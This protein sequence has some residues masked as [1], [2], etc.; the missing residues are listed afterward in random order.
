VQHTIGTVYG[1]MLNDPASLVRLA[2]QFSKDPYKAAPRAPILYI[3]PA[4]TLAGD[5][6]VV[7]VPAL[8]GR[9]QIGATIGV[10]LGK[11]AA[12]VSKEHALGYVD[13]FRIVA[14]VSL[15]HESFYR[16]AIRERCRDG[17]CPIGPLVKAPDF[18]AN[19]ALITL[20]INGATV[21]KP[22]LDDAVR[23]LDQLLADVTEFMTLRAG[24]VL[25][26]GLADQPP[27]AKPGDQISISVAGLGSLSFQLAQEDALVTP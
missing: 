7:Q 19:Q 3:K 12:R 20:S 11:T 13:G 21:Q 16:P 27:V 14:D 10:V 1:V 18:A 2:E 9:V 6:C 25:L 23:P 26:L 22:S 17:F 8:P 15:P 4:N 5:Q 24:D